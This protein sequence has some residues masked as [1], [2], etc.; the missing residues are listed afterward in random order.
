M[1][2]FDVVFLNQRRIPA[3]TAS[4]VLK[5][6]TKLLVPRYQEPAEVEAEAAAFRPAWH[7]VRVRAR[8]RVRVGVLTLQSGV[9]AH[10]VAS[11]LYLPCISP[12]SGE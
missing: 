5:K 4:A 12:M 3:I 1:E 8:V 7:V 2:V 9:L 10:H 11:L 6:G